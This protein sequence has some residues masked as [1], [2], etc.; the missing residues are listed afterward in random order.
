M[1]SEP[2]L[3]T[4]ATA[5][6]RSNGLLINS[7]AL[8]I[9][10]SLLTTVLHECA[11]FVPAYLYGFN[12][13]LHH[14]YVAY[15]SA[16]RLVSQQLL[17]AAAGPGF[18]LLLG[19]VCLWLSTRLTEKGLLSLFLL[20][21]GL[22]GVLAFFGYLFAAP[23][24]TYGDTG[25]IFAKLGLP[26]WL[27]IVISV[28]SF[29]VLNVILKR[30]AFAFRFYG[31]IGQSV[32]QRANALILFP[33]LASVASAVLHLPVTTPLSIIAPAITPTIFLSIYG[34][35][36]RT[37]PGQP[38]VPLS[39]ISWLLMGLTAAMIVVFRLLN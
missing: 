11:H 2:T 36:R 32:Q 21:M 27:V 18:S 25:F 26:T 9:L 38:T 29:V 4:P 39:Q 33:M 5:P 16:G 20:W 7:I 15:D 23:F 22:Q 30:M 13:V 12:P 3:Q 10:T 8:I 35:F 31:S 1:L 14:N 17:I 6:V 28:S 34:T 37:D 24:F 19:V